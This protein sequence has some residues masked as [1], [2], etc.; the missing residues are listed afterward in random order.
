MKTLKAQS[1]KALSIAGLSIAS[2]M[3]LSNAA[4]AE[5]ALKMDLQA[6]Q[7]ITD[8][9]GKISYVPVTAANLGATIQ[10][11]AIYHNTLNSSI[12]DVLVI[13]P[14]PQN[15]TFTGEAVPASAQATVDGTN[16]ADMPLMRRV[17]G[18]LEA[19][20][21]SEYKALRWNI[22]YLPAKKSAFVFLNATVN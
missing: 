22:K 17:N 10:Y 8:A 7:V 1:L 21:Y 2:T 14:I 18:K 5:D 9:Q 19:I 11:K 12:N 6:N 16:F 4:N 15:M 20:P 3:F 13:L